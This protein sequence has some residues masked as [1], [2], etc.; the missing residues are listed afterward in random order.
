LGEIDYGK[1]RNGG[2]ICKAGFQSSTHSPEDFQEIGK[3]SGY[4]YQVREVD[5]SSVF[6]II[7]KK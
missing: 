6:L 7:H 2:I 1:S 3:R 5:E 4:P